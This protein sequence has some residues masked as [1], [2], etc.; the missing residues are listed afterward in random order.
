MSTKTFHFGGLEFPSKKA[1]SLYLSDKLSEYGDEESVTDPEL[2]AVLSA[3][4]RINYSMRYP[5]PNGP[6]KFMAQT[7]SGN[8]NFQAILASGKSV[9]LSKNLRRSSNDRAHR[10]YVRE[11]RRNG[12]KF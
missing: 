9:V 11:L 8:K 7:I 4:W 5:E 6:E 12:N 1:V 10:H 3:V 2:V